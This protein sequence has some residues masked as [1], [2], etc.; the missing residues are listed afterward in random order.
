M[1]RPKYW[2]V[3]EPVIIEGERNVL[4]WYPRAKKLQI[5]MTSFF[6]DGVEM[7]SKI[8][9]LDVYHMNKNPETREQFKALLESILK[10]SQ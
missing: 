4:Y 8:I 7:P 6:R 9:T 1:L 5:R 2:Q 3:E 10:E